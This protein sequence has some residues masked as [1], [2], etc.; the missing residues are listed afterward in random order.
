MKHMPTKLAATCPRRSQK[1]K[2]MRLLTKAAKSSTRTPSQR[3]EELKVKMAAE[4]TSITFAKRSSYFASK[5]PKIKA[6]ER[7][8]LA[9]KGAHA[10]D[11]IH[12]LSE[13]S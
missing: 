5:N 11:A 13:A 8:H 7:T 12:H 10:D 2:P 3:L 4:F 1:P 6:T 9:S